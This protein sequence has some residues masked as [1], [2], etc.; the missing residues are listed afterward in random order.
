MKKW[1][2]F[3]G[4]LVILGLSMPVY[5][6]NIT[7]YDSAGDL[8]QSLVGS[9]V[10]I[11][12]VTYT[13]ST[14]AAG[15]FTGGTADGIGIENGIVMTSGYASNLSGTGN[16]SDS[17]TGNLGGAGDSTL[18]T[19]I[20]SWDTTYDATVLEF[21]F[22]SI[23]DAAYFNYV[24]GSEEYNEYVN[25]YNDV[26]GF[27]INGHNVALIPGTTTP[28]SVDTVNLN[29]NSTYYNNNDPSDTTTPYGI[30][31]DGFTD[32][33]MASILGL[34]AGQTYHIKLAISDTNDH[35]LDSGVFLQA[36]SFSN[37]PTPPAPVPEPA[38]LLLLG[39]GLVGLG[40]FGRKRAKI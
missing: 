15:Y 17:I 38:T 7:A 20:D 26:F 16:N 11:S 22:V 21:D 19:L 32:V 40:A 18:N 4:F 3:L 34:T 31:Y 33:F 25:S 5:A 28:V 12:H 27:F 29:V 37:I 30:E 8:A 9:G 36:G 24:F 6:L 13:G 39:S 1:I 23:G 14:G 2:K 35:I 10:A